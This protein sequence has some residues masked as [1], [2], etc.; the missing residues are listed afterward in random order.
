MGR[1]R[2][3]SPASSGSQTRNERPELV[4]RQVKYNTSKDVAQDDRERKGL[5]V[6][7]RGKQ[8]TLA[9]CVHALEKRRVIGNR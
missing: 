5:E 6:A 2:A 1:D 4:A 8:F 3:D 9:G 7:D